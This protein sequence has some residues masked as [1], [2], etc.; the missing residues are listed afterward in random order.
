MK[1]IILMILCMAVLMISMIG[2][3]KEKEPLYYEDI[4]TDSE[5]IKEVENALKENPL[6]K[7]EYIGT[8]SIIER[9]DFSFFGSYTVRVLINDKYTFDVAYR[10]TS[11]EQDGVI[12]KRWM[13]DSIKEVLNTN[14]KGE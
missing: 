4:P 12:I 7:E 3:A 8:I 13:R 6:T 5:I 1:K 9:Y 14:Q 2:C 10:L 11:I